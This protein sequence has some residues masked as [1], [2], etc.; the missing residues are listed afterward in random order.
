MGE[1]PI[2]RSRHDFRRYT[3]FS[4]S[5]TVTAVSDTLDE[6]TETA[7]YD[8]AFGDDYRIGATGRHTVSIEDATTPTLSFMAGTMS[9]DEAA[10]A[11]VASIVVSADS[12]LA[13][14]LVVPYTITA[15]TATAGADYMEPS[16]LSVTLARGTAQ[17]M[18]QLPILDDDVDEEDEQL[19]LELTPSTADYQLGVASLVLTI[20]DNDEPQLVF[21]M[22]SASQLEGAASDR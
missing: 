9:V 13:T 16:P 4:A 20:T 11:G 5:F 7:V 21:S 10:P 19:T 15:G 1:L 6:L 17:A 18:I 22:A 3:S 2:S 8:L 14:D 12:M